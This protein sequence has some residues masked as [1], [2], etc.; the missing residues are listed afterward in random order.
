MTPPP[1]RQLGPPIRRPPPRRPPSSLLHVLPPDAPTA[2]LGSVT[3]RVGLPT[4]SP[5]KAPTMAKGRAVQASATTTVRGRAA[6]PATASNGLDAVAVGAVATSS[7]SRPAAPASA[8]NTRC[9][10]ITHGHTHR[11]PS[12]YRFVHRW[13][14]SPPNNSTCSRRTPLDLLQ[15]SA[16]VDHRHHNSCNNSPGC[17]SRRARPRR[18]CLGIRPASSATAT[19]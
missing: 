17:S 5:A 14:P 3:A 19:P 10:T 4:A 8:R 13:S 7:S 6:L 12:G 16:M 11:T 1:V 18:A 2:A 15:G 9:T